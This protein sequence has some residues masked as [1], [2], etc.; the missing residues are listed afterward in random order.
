MEDKKITIKFSTL[1]ILLLILVIIFIYVVCYIAHI[2]SVNKQIN[3]GTSIPTTNGGV[4]NSIPTENT[5]ENINSNTNAPTNNTNNPSTNNQSIQVQTSSKSN[6]LSIG[7]WGMAS[8]YSDGQYVD[9]PVQ[10]Y[11][12]IR[13]SQAAQKVKEYCEKSST[14]YVTTTYK[15]AREGCEWVVVEYNIDLTNV[16]S[17]GMKK[18]LTI[19]SSV[20]GTGDLSFVVYNNYRYYVSTTI[21]GDRNTTANIGTG[22]FA[23]E[24][25][26]G[27]ADY[28]ITL[29]VSNHEQAF[30]TGK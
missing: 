5:N 19:Q 2:T 23:F 29:G 25:P 24:M 12:I 1:I 9:V 28:I 4:Q 18:D 20:I 7:L 6:P 3:N 14:S 30:F 10:V 26:I 11:N 16:K 21:I 17:I 22:A 8:K 15:D 13:G 27:C